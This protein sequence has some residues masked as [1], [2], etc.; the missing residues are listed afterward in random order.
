MA[1]GAAKHLVVEECAA[2][3]DRIDDRQG[4]ALVSAV[5]EAEKVYFYGVGRVLLS[6]QAVCKRLAH[7][8]IDAHYVGEITEPAITPRDL[9][10]VASG[11]G[12]SVCPRGIAEK[13]KRLGVRLAWIGSNEDS[14]IARLCDIRLRMPV[15]TKLNRSDELPSRQPMTSLFE[16]C[17]LLYGDAMAVEIIRRKELDLSALWQYHANLE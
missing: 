15:Q 13:A 11:S 5:L 9:L 6:L 3:L 7:L 12:E 4:E 8:G 1:L 16:Q 10:I 14:T 17:L 2:A